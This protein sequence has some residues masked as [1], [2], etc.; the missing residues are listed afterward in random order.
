MEFNVVENRKKTLILKLT[1]KPIVFLQCPLKE[2]GDKEK[3]EKTRE[4]YEKQIKE[5]GFTVLVSPEKARYV[6]L[7]LTQETEKFYVCA[8]QGFTKRKNG[9]WQTRM[10]KG[11]IKIVSEIEATGIEIDIPNIYQGI[12]SP[13]NVLSPI[14]FRW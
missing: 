7:I 8:S 2:L 14:Y 1:G 12:M 13:T 9:Q 10:S 3:A 4:E 6:I 5:A 11:S